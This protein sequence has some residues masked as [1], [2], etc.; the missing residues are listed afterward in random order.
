M[1]DAF[2]S[3]FYGAELAKFNK[4]QAVPLRPPLSA[5]CAFIA[6]SLLF[7]YYRYATIIVGLEKVLL[8]G[9]AHMQM[10]HKKRNM[11]RQLKYGE[12]SW[13]RCRDTRCGKQ[14]GCRESV[15]KGRERGK[16]REGIQIERE[17]R[18]KGKVKV[19]LSRVDSVIEHVKT[20]SIICE[21]PRT[22]HSTFSPS[23]LYIPLSLCLPLSPLPH[24]LHALVRQA[25]F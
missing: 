15:E 9:H 12:I 23:L 20:N 1:S 18:G 11:L 21:I 6:R 7:L 10:C 13:R 5:N 19:V 16:E 17:G 4:W 14:Q 24:A 2:S 25:Y 22:Q 8:E 3:L